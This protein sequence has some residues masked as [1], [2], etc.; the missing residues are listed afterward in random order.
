MWDGGWR[1]LLVEFVFLTDFVVLTMLV[2]DELRDL[3]LST[4][5]R[6]EEHAR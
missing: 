6:M 3:R 1:D 4:S 2:R 5:A